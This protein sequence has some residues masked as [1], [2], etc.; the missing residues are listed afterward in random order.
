MYYRHSGQFT[1]AGV[2]QGLLAGGL[3]AIVMAFLYAYAIL[4]IPFIYINFF[5]AVGYGGILGAIVA[6]VLKA[7][8][9]R[10]TPVTA[11]VALGVGFIALY[12]S[13]AVWVYGILGRADLK[14]D[15][16]AIATHPVDLWSLI[17]QINDVGAWKL[18]G[19]TPTGIILWIVWGLEAAIIIGAAIGSAIA[20][21]SADPYCEA[22]GTWCVSVPRVARLQACAPAELKPRIEGKDWAFLESLGA[23]PVDASNSLQVDL[24]RCKQCGQTSTLTIQTVTVTVDRKNRQSKKTRSVLDKLLV[25]P[26]ECETIQQIGQRVAVTS[27]P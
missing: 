3:A 15:L 4:Y 12:A 20:M 14:R 27:G 10:S 5:L 25:T 24:H 21:T 18:G 2:V 26:A 11:A 1:V 16:V 19:S 8:Q 6:F 22:C 17:L 13:W 7:R 9:V 23:A